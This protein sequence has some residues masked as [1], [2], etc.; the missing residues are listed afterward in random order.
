MSIPRHKVFISYYNEDDKEYKNHLIK[1]NELNKNT[2]KEQSIFEECS[3]HE[4][5]I[6]DTGLTDNQIRRIIR[7]KYIKDATVF[8]LLCGQNTKY[9]DY[10][11][12]EIFIAM[13][14]SKNNRQ[15]GLLVIN[16]PTIKQSVRSGSDDEKPLLSDN[17]NWYS[18]PNRTEFEKI[19]P[20]VPSRIIDNF[21]KHVPITVVNW[22]RI[23]CNTRRLKQLINN[24]YNRRFDCKYEVSAPLK[25][26]NL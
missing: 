19:Y 21:Y 24:A 6:D 25:R 8:I 11:D 15:L 1:M 10:L 3:F 7:D 16:L 26:A 20:F 2:W 9:I 13:C 17:A 14:D 18:C 23:R 12:W 22:D 4:D 5:E